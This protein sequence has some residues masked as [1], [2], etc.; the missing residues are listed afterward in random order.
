MKKQRSVQ[1][2]KASKQPATK[3]DLLKDLHT[4]I[5]QA[6]QSV[7]L[8]INSSLTLLYWHVGDRMRREILL[9]ER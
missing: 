2:P 9:E 1:K 6:R 5:Q 4:M 3:G 7:A 8:A